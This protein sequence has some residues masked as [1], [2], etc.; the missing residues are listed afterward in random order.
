MKINKDYL[1]IIKAAR[2]GGEVV[3][4]YFGKNIKITTP[5]DLILAEA[6]ARCE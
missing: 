5:E 6:I 4:K 1:E 3:K 2:A